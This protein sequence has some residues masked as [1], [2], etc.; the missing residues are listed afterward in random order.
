MA[1]PESRQPRAT[2]T[3]GVG[4]DYRSR[5][6]TLQQFASGDGGSVYV[7]DAPDGYYI[8]TDE[9]VLIDFL[10]EGEPV[11]IIRAFDAVT[12]RD[13]YCNL[14]FGQLLRGDLT[15]DSLSEKGRP[16][17]VLS[18]MGTTFFG[19]D[20]FAQL[21]R[22]CA[23]ELVSPTRS[24]VALL[25]AWRQPAIALA[26][27]TNAL[28]TQFDAP[29]ALQFEHAVQVNQGRGKASFTDLMVSAPTHAI[30]IE[31]K[32]TEPVYD[33][34]AAWLERGA[35][36]GPEAIPEEMRR[37]FE[38]RRRVLQG[39][40]DLICRATGTSITIEQVK[41]C[42][43]QLI[44]RTASVCHQTGRAS[45]TVAYQCF[46]EA[47]RS[48]PHEEYRRQLAKLKSIIGPQSGLQ[49][50][51]ILCPMQVT[52]RFQELRDRRRLDPRV[53]LSADVGAGLVAG[54]LLKFGDWRVTLI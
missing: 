39:W 36:N 28:G 31:A 5:F 54:D 48:V 3:F 19:P 43:Y 27:L 46:Y 4:Y 23:S 32:F 13:M 49:F 33:T 42:T 26:Q 29:V 15:T 24:T 51:L 21:I 25:A 40:L 16:D 50:V 1:N 12:D 10:D 37:S 11:I 6:P 20:A 35:R 38:N 44:H 52:P 2:E 41:E 9:G 53:D 47:D 14:R 34:V 30:G 17:Y 22:A 45:L 18:W 7:A 8:V